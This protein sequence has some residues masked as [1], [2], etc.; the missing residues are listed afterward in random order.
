M[1]SPVSVLNTAEALRF[2]A[3]DVAN[4]LCT[5]D[6]AGE[7]YHGGRHT[8]FVRQGRKPLPLYKVEELCE[9]CAA[10]WHAVMAASL[11]DSV[12]ISQQ[13]LGGNGP[14]DGAVV[15]GKMVSGRKPKV[16]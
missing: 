8:C 1:D 16:K 6:V 12:I 7:C 13:F 4:V 15:H 5:S 3:H 9:R 11:L 2:A 14:T 10:S